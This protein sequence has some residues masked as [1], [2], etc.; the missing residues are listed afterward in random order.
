[1]SSE[2]RKGRGGVLGALKNIGEASGMLTFAD[3][4]GQPAAV[5]PIAATPA[6]PPVMP[7]GLTAAASGAE[8]PAEVD[9]TLTIPFSEL[10][11][12]LGALGNPL[13]DPL[14]TAFTQMAPSLKGDPLVTAMKAMMQG[15]NID[16]AAVFSTLGQRLA[17]LGQTL[18]NENGKAGSRKANRDQDLAAFKEQ[19]LATIADLERQIA[20]LRQSLADK[21]NETVQANAGD[22]GTMKAFEQKVAAE[23]AR[24]TELKTFL[25]TFQEGGEKA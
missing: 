12:R 16:L 14:L 11:A 15:M 17:A 22:F 19:S 1:M 20:E 4:P 24:L 21:D 5:S 2:G 23:Q 9:D 10:Y 8:A 25:G 6:P 13:T 18:T 3:E 7:L